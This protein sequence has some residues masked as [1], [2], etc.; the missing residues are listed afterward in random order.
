MYNLL[1]RI[2]FHLGDYQAATEL[3]LESLSLAVLEDRMSMKMLNFI[4]LADVRLAENRL[5]EAQ[6]YCDHAL[7]VARFMQE[8]HHLVGVMYMV[9]GKVAF[10]EAK[11]AQ[12]E[13][14]AY[15]LQ[16]AQALYKKAEEHLVQTQATMHLAELYGRQAEMYEAL[17]RHEEALAAWKLA[18]NVRATA[19]GLGWYE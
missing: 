6:R 12:G 14:A 19:K 9:Y 17:N 5:E 13:K 10:A 7:E 1:A 3:Y 11:E 2:A 16:E 15:L 18:F 8:D 4:A